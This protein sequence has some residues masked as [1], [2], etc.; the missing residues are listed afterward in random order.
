MAPARG[1]LSAILLV[2]VATWAATTRGTSSQISH[3]LT[4][5][6]LFVRTD[7]RRYK[8][9]G[10]IGILSEVLRV[11]GGQRVQE[12]KSE[13]PLDAYMRGIDEQLK[14]EEAEGDDAIE[15]DK[16]G[17]HFLEGL[18]RS[19]SPGFEY[20]R[21][22]KKRGLDVYVK[23][24]IDTDQDSEEIMRR[25]QKEA[26]ENA[27]KEEKEK[28]DEHRALEA[29]EENPDEVW[30]RK[31]K[32]K[33][34]KFD[35][36]G[37]AKASLFVS[38]YPIAKNIYNP[39]WNQTSSNLKRP[40]ETE[41]EKRR[42]ELEIRVEGFEIQ[43]PEVDFETIGL[44]KEMLAILKK[45]DFT[46]PMPIQSQ[47]IPIALTGRDLIGVAPTGTGKTL[48]FVIPMILHVRRN[49]KARPMDK[50][51]GPIG[52]VVAPTRE[53]ATQI[54]TEAM[55]M[56]K[57]FGLVVKACYGGQS[58]AEQQKSL[59]HGVDIIVCTPGRMM[60]LIKIKATSM[61]QISFLVFDEADRLL[62]S[63]FEYQVR[64]M[65]ERIRPDRQV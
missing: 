65:L 29:L 20:M 5:R 63:G 21:Y 32:V 64:S 13:D 11:S 49:Y 10:G 47:C 4:P 28:S 39:L 52:M 15:L 40:D 33:P 42:E 31:R 53:L 55:R 6:R 34:L 25:Q 23:G 26:E 56:A 37:G 17:A 38:K 36:E 54:T 61:V 9:Y 57:P 35:E 24:S 48:G 46:G 1:P 27:Q 59:S 8:G 60:D 51:R 30:K 43:P 19:D 62:D 45:R 2:L 3:N 16:K 44:P 7:Y 50:R 58:K 14:K 18:E 12:D 22:R 41:I